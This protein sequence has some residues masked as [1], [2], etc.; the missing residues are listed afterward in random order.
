MHA[1]YSG[2]WGAHRGSYIAL[3]GKDA[4]DFRRRLF[5]SLAVRDNDSVNTSFNT[6][7][8][9]SVPRFV[10][11]EPIEEESDA[12]DELKQII[13][14]EDESETSID[15]VDVLSECPPETDS[16]TMN[17]FRESYRVVLPSL[18]QH[19]D[20]LSVLFIPTTRFVELV[21]LVVEIQRKSSADP[22]AVIESKGSDGKVR[23][24]TFDDVMA[25][26]SVSHFGV[27][28]RSCGG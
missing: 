19:T 16:L 2:I 24:E 22:V 25:E 6:R 3:R 13:V 18:P 17:P 28:L 4:S 1:C 20:D 8:M 11:Y 15:V 12:V 21:K 27:K 9:I 10:W 26:H 5:R 7:T 23:W 14:A